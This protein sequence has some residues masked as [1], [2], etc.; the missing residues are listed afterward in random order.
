[1]IAVTMFDFDVSLYIKGVIVFQ[2]LIKKYQAIGYI[3]SLL[4]PYRPNF[5]HNTP[6]KDG[7]YAN[8]YVS[9]WI[10]MVHFNN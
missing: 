6:K 5:M 10:D 8:Y 3:F 9:I 1:M 2:S 7:S 4:V